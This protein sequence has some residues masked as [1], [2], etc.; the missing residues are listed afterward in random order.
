M[1]KKQNSKKGRAFVSK[2]DKY[3]LYKENSS[4]GLAA[5][6]SRNSRNSRLF[7]LRYL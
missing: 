5:R 3:I 6:N 7:N 4:S 1:F 2:G